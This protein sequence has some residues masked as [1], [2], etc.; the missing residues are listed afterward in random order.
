M[1]VALVPVVPLALWIGWLSWQVGDGLS[2]KDNFSWPLVGLV[3]SFSEWDTT[4]DLVQA[5]VALLALVGAG[6]PWS[7]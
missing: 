5:L 7:R 1:A 3:E 2:A 4:G 6:L